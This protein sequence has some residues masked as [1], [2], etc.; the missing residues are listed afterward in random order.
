MLGLVDYSSSSS[1]SDEE[2]QIDESDS[3][4]VI[5]CLI[6]DLLSKIVTQS[7]Q[8]PNW[9]KTNSNFTVSRKRI[10]S[11]SSS[12]SSSSSESSSSSSD[13][14]EEEIEPKKVIRKPRKTK[15]ELLP[16]D[17]PPIEDL[18]ISVP[19]YEAVS[20]GS[21]SSVVGNLVVVKAF[22]NTPALDI[23]TVLFLNK[24]TRSLG[25][26]FDTFGPVMTP[27]YSVRFNAAEDIGVKEIEVGMEVFCAP[28]TEHTSYVFIEELRKLKGS[29][30]SWRHDEEPPLKHLDFSDDEEERKAKNPFYR[31]Q[32]RYQPSELGQIKWNSGH[33]QHQQQIIHPSNHQVQSQQSNRIVR[34]S[35]F[36]PGQFIEY[37]NNPSNAE[38]SGGSTLPN[39][40][41]VNAPF[42]MHYDN[43]AFKQ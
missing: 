36:L 19:E 30:A 24:G 13:E 27:Y 1:S 32:R 21:I 34:P 41:A 35:A 2:I 7:K 42:Q 38:E 26:V 20:I 14:E 43:N 16:V 10:I 33:V 12:S 9:L 40:F 4:Q 3:N 15:H 22:P 5:K 23:D 31:R 8:S 37:G 11:S 17:L 28:R 6:D 18:Q 29:D 39:P 25:R